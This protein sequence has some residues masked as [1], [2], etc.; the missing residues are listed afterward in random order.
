MLYVED[1]IEGEARFFSEQG[2]LTQI[3]E[4]I[5]GKLKSIKKFK[6]SGDVYAEK[7]F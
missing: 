4:Y 3:N 5:E 7:V 6:E 2:F 1:S